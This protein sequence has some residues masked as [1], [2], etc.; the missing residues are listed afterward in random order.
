MAVLDFSNGIEPNESNL[1]NKT[2]HFKGFVT[3]K[4]AFTAAP[5]PMIVGKM[6]FEP[7]CVM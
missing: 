2:S 1:D 4:N 5:F 3:Q 6:L 7:V